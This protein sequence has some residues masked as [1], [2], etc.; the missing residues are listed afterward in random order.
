MFQRVKD[1]K[2][3]GE[4]TVSYLWSET[5]AANI[6]ARI[7]DAK[8]V[9]VLRDPAERATLVVRWV[10]L[11]GTGAGSAAGS[12]VTSGLPAGMKPGASAD[13][14]MRLAAP[15]GPGEYLLV[16]DVLDPQRGSLVAAGVPPGIVRVTVTG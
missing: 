9:M 14:T 13:V 16:V 15:A 1:E 2:A 11:G 12:V 4:A 10:D 8:I 6:H 3:I 5:A 7:P